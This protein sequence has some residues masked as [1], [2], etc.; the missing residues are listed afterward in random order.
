[1]Q[2]A[3]IDRLSVIALLCLQLSG[4]AGAVA[5]ERYRQEDALRWA[6]EH[7]AAIFDRLFPAAGD[8]V[9]MPICRMTTIRSSGS[10][11]AFEFMIRIIEDCPVVDPA[12]GKIAP[13]EVR[14]AFVIPEGSPIDDQLATLRLPDPSLTPEAAIARIKLRT[15][16]ISPSQARRLLKELDSAPASLLP[17][18]EIALDA[19][20]Y[21]VKSSTGMQ[22][23]LV[24]FAER[25]SSG[26]DR[27]LTRVINTT[28]AAL[29]YGRDRLEYDP[30]AWTE[31]A[32]GV[33]PLRRRN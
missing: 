31:N 29:G 4:A 32:P 27:K 2:I 22:T 26:R 11:D 23:R 20:M 6:S 7:R 14:G 1:M 15:L 17:P 18:V 21:E 30:A 19:R 16:L 13:A 25:S 3:M 12:T 8:N 33:K 24:M 9:S 28:L 10:L 5:Q